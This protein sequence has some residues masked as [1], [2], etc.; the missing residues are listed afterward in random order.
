M[1]SPFA[2]AGAVRDP[3]APT[4]HGQSGRHALE[5]AVTHLRCLTIRAVGLSL[6]FVCRCLGR[7]G[8]GVDIWASA[9]AADRVFLFFIE[10]TKAFVVLG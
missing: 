1:G 8:G 6:S 7:D 3:P 4:S 5:V 9:V 2:V 10:E